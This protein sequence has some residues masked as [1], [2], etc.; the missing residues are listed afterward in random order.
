MLDERYGR[1]KEIL[2]KQI[3]ALQQK[4]DDA[5]QTGTQIVEVGKSLLK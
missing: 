4:Q 2:E 3:K 5:D 1:Q